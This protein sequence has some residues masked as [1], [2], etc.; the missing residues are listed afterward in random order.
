MIKISKVSVNIGVGSESDNLK[1]AEL[2]L[3]RMF[4]AKPVRTIAKAAVPDFNI[5]Y[6]NRESW[7]D[8]ST[9]AYFT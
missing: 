9:L 4:T 1:K 6:L 7:L 5:R 2:L 8:N 3:S